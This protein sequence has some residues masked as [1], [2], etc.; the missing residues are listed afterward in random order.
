MKFRGVSVDSFFR[1]LQ[2]NFLTVKS[3]PS[4][5]SSRIVIA[6]STE[7]TYR[8]RQGRPAGPRVSL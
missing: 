3:R 6:T 7:R 2:K 8:R 5:R 1:L 4:E